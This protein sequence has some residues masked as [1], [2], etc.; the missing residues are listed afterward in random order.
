VEQD[1]LAEFE[2]IPPW[3][4]SGPAPFGSVD[5]IRTALPTSDVDAA[6]MP[7]DL[8]PG[9]VIDGRIMSRTSWGTSPRGTASTRT[10]RPTTSCSIRRQRS[11][12]ALFSAYQRPSWMSTINRHGAK[13]ESHDVLMCHIKWRP[14]VLYVVILFCS[15]LLMKSMG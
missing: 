5:T 13:I 6:T 2:D 4:R 8:G 9:R 7:L 14:Y 11:S 10:I 15:L 12:W 3:T 1:C